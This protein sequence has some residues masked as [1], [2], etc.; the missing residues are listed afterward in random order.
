MDYAL[1]THQNTLYLRQARQI[2]DVIFLAFNM[3]LPKI[4]APAQS[5]L[6]L[7]AIKQWNT[8]NFK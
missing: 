1:A 8:G 6:L 3:Y 4:T 7:I 5:P 2:S